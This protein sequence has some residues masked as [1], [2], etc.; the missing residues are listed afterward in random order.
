MPLCAD[1]QWLR[2]DDEMNTDGDLTKPLLGLMVRPQGGG[3]IVGR[4]VRNN[5]DRF[6]A[7]KWRLGKFI[8]VEE[9][10]SLSGALKAIE[11][12]KS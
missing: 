12:A 7:Q 1:D 6:L 10:P 4:I 9:C 11:E 8:D 2:I 5:A 3:M